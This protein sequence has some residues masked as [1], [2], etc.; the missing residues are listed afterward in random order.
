MYRNVL[1]RAIIDRMQWGG[2]GRGN[3]ETAAA[4]QG[5]W[6]KGLALAPPTPNPLSQWESRRGAAD[7]NTAL[8]RPL[9][10]AEILEERKKGKKRRKY[11]V[12]NI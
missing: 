10:I 6:V 3:R 9:R 2:A 12:V 8:W 1:F 11:E 7:V 5:G 4:A